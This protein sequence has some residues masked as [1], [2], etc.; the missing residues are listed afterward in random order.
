MERIKLLSLQS[1]MIK[2]ALIHHRQNGI[3]L[4][5]EEKEEKQKNR[6]AQTK[7]KF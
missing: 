7:T 5:H 1:N 4:P 6:K 2:S 3:K